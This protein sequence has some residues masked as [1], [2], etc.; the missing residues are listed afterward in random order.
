MKIFLQK[1]SEFNI[2]YKPL[3]G[4]DAFKMFSAFNFK[5]QDDV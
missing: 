4:K 5:T 2:L 3:S 1:N